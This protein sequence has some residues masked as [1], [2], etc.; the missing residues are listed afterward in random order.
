MKI[1]F[2]Y[3]AQ[4]HQI[5]HSLP[6]ALELAAN[7]RNIEVDIAVVSVRH[8]DFAKGLAS[9]YG[10]PAP[11]RFVLLRRPLWAHLRSLF[12]GELAP[13]KKRTLLRNLPYFASCD[14]IVTPE[15]TTLFLRDY[16]RQLPTRLIYTGHGAGDRAMAVA[17]EIQ[18]FDFV[19][20]PGVKL[21][22]RRL[23]LGLIRP[24]A[25][26]SGIYAKFDWVHRNATERRPL[27]DNDRPTILYSPHFD[28][29]LSSWPL[30]GMEVLKYFAASTRYNLI[31][32]PHVRLFEP[33]QRSKYR[34]FRQFQ[35]LGHMHID[36][37]SERSID[38]SYTL[39][40]DAYLG[41]VSSQVAEFLVRPRPCVFLNPCGTAWQGDKNYRFWT[42]GPVV[43][44][45]HQ[46]DRGLQDAFDTHDAY[47]EL[48]RAYFSETFD[49]AGLHPSAR[50]GADAIAEFLYGSHRSA[51]NFPTAS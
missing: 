48:Q 33:P 38:M 49:G 37:G 28:P 5:P 50:Q 15:R 6:I 12:G 51:N 16:T 17:P 27:F 26:V 23:A 25:Y 42:L 43:N 45:V 34:P 8:L 30:C 40:A 32:A 7:H 39:G 24:G 41:D 47:L 46:L 21:E 1:S 13:S 35:N 4:L 2:L 9:S 44:G 20:N 10:I 11:V 31:F 3:N 18:D 22:Q 14:A 36:L 19:L 29:T